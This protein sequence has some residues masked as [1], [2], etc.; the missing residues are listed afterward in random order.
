MPSTEREWQQTMQQ[1]KFH[2]TLEDD[3]CQQYITTH[4]WQILKWNVV[5]IVI[6]ATRRDYV[7]LAPPNSF[8]FA[9]DFDSFHKLIDYINLLNSNDRLYNNFFAWKNDFQI[10]SNFS[11]P[12]MYSCAVACKIF[13]HYDLSSKEESEMSSHFDPFV[14]WWGKSFATCGKHDWIRKLT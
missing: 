6:G 2:I 5:P 11:F 3:C 8:I 10:N 14:K 13:N 1:Y 9:D 7:N 12:P 4:F